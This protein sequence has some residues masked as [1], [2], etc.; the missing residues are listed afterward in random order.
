M[1]KHK[2]YVIEGGGDTGVDALRIYPDCKYAV[3][4]GLYLQCGHPDAKNMYCGVSC[5]AVGKPNRCPWRMKRAAQL[6][7]VRHQG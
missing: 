7:S 3:K 6:A 2:P 5:G 4:R 1:T